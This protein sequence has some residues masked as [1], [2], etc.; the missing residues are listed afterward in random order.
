M[1]IKVKSVR[2]YLIDDEDYEK[3]K[4]FKWHLSRE[5]YIVRTMRIPN[6]NPKAKFLHRLIMGEPEGFE[7]DHINRNKLDNRKSNLR[8]CTT[9][10]NRWNAK[11]SS[12]KSMTSKYRGVHF[13]KSLQR[14]VAKTKYRGKRIHI[15]C[16]D[17]E[18]KAAKAYDNLIVK[19]KG[20]FAKTNFGVNNYATRKPM[21]DEAIRV[22]QEEKK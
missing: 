13:S 10:E 8:I 14:F 6:R 21:A 22:I 9:T 3:I 18:T 16:F 20:Q 2:T 17:T 19:L 7:V 11:K 15:G 4:P 12:N 1:K 5:G